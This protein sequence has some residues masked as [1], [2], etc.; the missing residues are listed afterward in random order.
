MASQIALLGTVTRNLR[1]VLVTLIKKDLTFLFYYDQ[2]PSEEEVRLSETVL[3]DAISCFEDVTGNVKRFVVPEPETKSF[4]DKGS[5][6]Y[7]RY[8][9][10]LADD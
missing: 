1:A 10:Y 9:D 5:S 8:E 2:E 7:W 3:H 4:R 6:V